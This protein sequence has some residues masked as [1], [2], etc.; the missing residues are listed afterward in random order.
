MY[1][2]VGIVYFVIC[3]SLSMLVKQL[4]RRVAIVR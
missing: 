2:F 3:L 4:Q 1:L